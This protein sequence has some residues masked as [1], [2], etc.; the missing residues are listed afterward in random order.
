MSTEDTQAG[1]VDPMLEAEFPGLAVLTRRCRGPVAGDAGVSERLD[2]VASRVR[3]RMALELRR[4]V[5]PAA[6]RAFYRQVG[7]DPD[8]EMTPV[9]AAIGRR[10]FDGGIKV[11]GP[12]RAALELAV[13]ET[14]APVYALDAGEMEGLPGIRAAGR[15]EELERADGLL[16]RSPGRLL[17]AD[18]NGPLCWLFEE[19]RG[20]AA[21]SDSTRALLL[22]A[23]GVPGTPPMVLDEALD[24]AS[25]AIGA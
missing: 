23:V 4:E 20:R 13:L 15:G 17:L 5:V 24:I 1:W 19:A 21:A 2:A 14:G 18:D 6:Y 25:G 7:L 16:G 3:G 12:L 9:E 11:D 22:V 8:V 10:L